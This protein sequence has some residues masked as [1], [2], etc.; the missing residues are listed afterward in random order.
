MKLTL[1]IVY[2]LAEHHD[3]G[4]QMRA[5]QIREK[6]KQIIQQ[7]ILFIDISISFLRILN[8]NP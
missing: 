1:I 4:R 6:F 8:P 3:Q 5:G 7:T 2:L